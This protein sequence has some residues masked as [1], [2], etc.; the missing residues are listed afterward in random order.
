MFRT[1]DPSAGRY[2]TSDSV[3]LLGGLNTFSY[4]LLNP[5]NYYDPN[6][7]SPIA[8][9]GV[10]GGLSGG[11]IAGAGGFAGGRSKAPATLSRLTKEL[12]D[13]FSPRRELPLF[14]SPDDADGDSDG[15]NCPLQCELLED[16]VLGDVPQPP[17]SIIAVRQKH[18]CVYDCGNFRFS[19]I[20]DNVMGCP[21]IG[22]PRDGE[23][24]TPP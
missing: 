20:I 14:L 9:G 12:R 16:I 24:T 10:G 21:K 23:P 11:S 22:V 4:A 19:R 2:L 17:G 3:G 6:G 7:R 1:Y 15:K 5:A 8:A 18:L 13:L